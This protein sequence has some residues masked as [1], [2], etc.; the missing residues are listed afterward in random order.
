MKN[1]NRIVTLLA[2]ALVITLISPIVPLAKAQD[3]DSTGIQALDEEN[4][5]KNVAERMRN[6]RGAQDEAYKTYSAELVEIDR[7]KAVQIGGMT[8]FAVQV[9]VHP[10]QG[11][12]T[13]DLISVVV[14]TAG[15]Y[16]FAEIQS[17]ADGRSMVREALAEVK[18]IDSLPPGL[19]KEIFTDAGVHDVL[20]ISDPFCPYCRRG[21][22][23]LMENREKIRTLRLAHFP[24]NDAAEATIWAVT[25]FWHKGAALETVQPFDA[26]DYAYSRLQ[27]SQ[28]PQDIIKQ[29]LE[30]W[31]ELKTR[32]GE[33]APTALQY[34]RQSYQ[35]EVQNE[36]NQVKALGIQS[37]PIFFIKGEMVEGF[38]A[39]RLDALLSQPQ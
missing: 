27:P 32:W 38:N 36:R 4:L 22:Q 31:P 15:A 14:D 18:R 3:S 10:P 19:G 11:D 28:N 17:L 25:D 9:K 16:Q 37:T 21:W 8:V 30:T 24:L 7:Q 26:L 34:L 2:I 39:N 20:V 23:Y 33:D 35:A 1:S 6:T 5:K 29:F 13:P 12:G